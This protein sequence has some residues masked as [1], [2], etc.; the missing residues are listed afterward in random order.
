MSGYYAEMC[1]AT[2]ADTVGTLTTGGELAPTYNFQTAAQALV[3][4]LVLADHF[5]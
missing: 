2:R 3:S 1:D 4:T 5:A